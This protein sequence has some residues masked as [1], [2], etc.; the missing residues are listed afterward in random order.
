MFEAR[1][2]LPA[3]AIAIDGVEYLLTRGSS[4]R[5]PGYARLGAAETRWVLRDWAQRQGLAA[6]GELCRAVGAWRSPHPP[7]DVDDCIDLLASR[8]DVGDPDLVLH[9]K[10]RVAVALDL[11][12]IEDVVDLAEAMDLTPEPELHWVEITFHDADGNPLPDAAVSIERPDGV[13]HEG[14]TNAAGVLRVSEISV[15]GPCKVSFPELEAWIREHFQVS[16]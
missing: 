3:H 13:T 8:F 5:V 12:E 10:I 9:R 15:A 6:L 7:G 4:A 16:A 1:V 14:R 2:V 11:S